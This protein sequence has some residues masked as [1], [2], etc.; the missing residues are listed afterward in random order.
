M[1]TARLL[2]ALPLALIAGGGAAAQPRRSMTER[3]A[4]AEQMLPW[5]TTRVVFGDQVQP[6]W[7]KDGTRFWFRNKTRTGAEFLHVDPLAG[8][9]RPLFD[10]GRLAAAITAAADT[11]Y[12]PN[13]L[14][15]QT[16]KFLKDGEDERNIEFRDRKSVV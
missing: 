8:T 10:N 6:Q 5:N 7:Y 2:L 9:V 16:F 13:K 1:R 3:Y 4:R 12:D 15:F 11:S 14:P